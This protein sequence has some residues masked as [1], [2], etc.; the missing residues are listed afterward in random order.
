MNDFDFLIGTWD[1]ANRWRTDFL[2]EASDWEEFP[3][4][5]SCS[6][7]FDGAANFD[8]I[9]FPTK[10]FSGLTLRLYDPEREEWSL[11]W[12]SKRTGTL[13][14]PVTGR[15]TDGRGVFLG[16]D[17]HDGKPIRARFVWSGVTATTAR[18]EQAFSQDGGAT[19]VTNW[20][21]E[22]TRR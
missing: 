10:G 13:F 19:W 21:M 3:G 8:E 18:W 11:Y 6:G 17:T 2:D 15:F 12:A 16:D 20:I 9:A 5:S 1:V 4:S 22:F 7:H 14:P